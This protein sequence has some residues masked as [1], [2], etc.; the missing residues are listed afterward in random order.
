MKLPKKPEK[1]EGGTVTGHYF[2]FMAETISIMNQYEEFKGHY[3]IMD[4]CP[5]H[6]HGD[7]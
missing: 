4:N 2:N 6:N 1:G 7:I 5:I 3:L